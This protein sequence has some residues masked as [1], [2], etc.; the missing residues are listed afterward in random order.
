MIM[1][2]IA[3]FAWLLI[4]AIVGAVASRVRRRH[5]ALT[6]NVLFG[7][8]GA[9]IGGIVFDLI[10]FP[11]ITDFNPLSVLGALIGAIVVLVIL[12]A[13][14]RR[15]FVA[16][17]QVEPTV[18]VGVAR[19]A[20]SG[21]LYESD[22]VVDRRRI[23][24]W[25][26]VVL[27]LLMPLLEVILL[28]IRVP[29]ISATP[30]AFGQ[31]ATY[32]SDQGVLDYLVYTPPTYQ[33]GTDLPLMVLL[34]GCMQDPYQ[35]ETASA[36]RT[37]ADQNS[38]MIVYP[39]QNAAFSPHRC[40]SWY[41]NR[42]QQR[43]SGEP[44]LLV[45][46]VNQVQQDYS[47]DSSRIYVAGISS[48]GA[49]TSILASCYPDVFA[50]AAVHSGMPYDASNSPIEAITAPLSGSETLPSTAG[51]N[52]YECAGAASQPIPVLIFHGA[53][54]TVVVVQNAHDALQQFAQTNDY[55]DDGT[56]NDSVTAQPT[57]IDT[58][59]NPDMHRYTVEYYEY[60]GELLL[61]RYIVEGMWHMW[62]GGSGIPPFSDPAAPN[63]SQVIWDF[64]SAHGQPITP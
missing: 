38:F 2:F 26:P 14:K 20:Q 23:P 50:A 48:G 22:A 56:D 47:V 28:R 16:V 60:N 39:Q 37:I 53:A 35:V 21:K 29:D 41:D 25:V 42:S 11:T 54:D 4:G 55:A 27:I 46:I 36:M 3:W 30:P 1:T 7:I 12:H 58:M 57:S 43:D 64:F 32:T 17:R 33:Q 13:L 24:I 15:H 19:T 6:T 8:L 59:Q 62:G 9:F 31:V 34:H 63:A 49:M 52:A 5:Y 51:A 10:G 44:S 40:W 18:D 61:Q 45:G